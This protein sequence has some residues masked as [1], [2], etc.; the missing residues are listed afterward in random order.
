MN[1]WKMPLEM[2]LHTPFLHL[3]LSL[4]LSLSLSLFEPPFLPPTTAQSPPLASIPS[5]L[6]SKLTGERPISDLKNNGGYDDDEPIFLSLSFSPQ[7]NKFVFL[8][9]QPTNPQ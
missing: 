4:S 1:L 7:S 5:L 9:P 6:H 8:E 2:A 3:H